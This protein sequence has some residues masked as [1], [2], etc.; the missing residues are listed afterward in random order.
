MAVEKNIYTFNIL[1]MPSELKTLLIKII[2]EKLKEQ[3]ENEQEK[4]I[5][6]G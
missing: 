1:P 5:V 6:S 3:S 4:S 2:Y